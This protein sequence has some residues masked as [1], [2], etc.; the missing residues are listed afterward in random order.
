MDES[1]KFY[2]T[3]PTSLPR[4]RLRGVK[5]ANKNFWREKPD[6]WVRFWVKLPPDWLNS[7]PPTQKNL[8]LK[9]LLNDYI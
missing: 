6:D 4:L 7:P 1:V 8:V 2:I 3:N 5:N 9:V